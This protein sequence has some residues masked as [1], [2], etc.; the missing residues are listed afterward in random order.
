MLH[1]DYCWWRWWWWWWWGGDRGDTS[2]ETKARR[3]SFAHQK[4]H[5]SKSVKISPAKLSYF[6]KRINNQL[7][8]EKTTR[9]RDLIAAAPLSRQRPVSQLVSDIW[10]GQR[11][12]PLGPFGQFMDPLTKRPSQYTSMTKGLPCSFQIMTIGALICEIWPWRRASWTFYGP[13]TKWPATRF[14]RK[15]IVVRNHER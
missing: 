4:V 2:K 1:H 6:V 9:S 12:G 14:W 5:S 13:F 3:V 8:F 7:V 15:E 10:P 11:L